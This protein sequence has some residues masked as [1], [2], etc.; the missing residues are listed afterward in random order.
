MHQDRDTSFLRQLLVEVC[1]GQRG[2]HSRL[3]SGRKSRAL[4]QQGRGVPGAWTITASAQIAEGDGSQHQLNPGKTPCR[5]LQAKLK[6]TG[7][8]AKLH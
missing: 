6:R 8:E 3:W 4:S 5:Y 1:P 7:G 2:V